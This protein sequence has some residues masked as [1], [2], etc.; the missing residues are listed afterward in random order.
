[1]CRYG[2]EKLTESPTVS[3]KRLMPAMTWG[4]AVRVLSA[5][6]RSGSSGMF[7]AIRPFSGMLTAMGRS[8]AEAAST[9][10]A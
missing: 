2:F 8:N 7:N 3:I 6:N 4:C 5:P 1:M 9:A 10:S